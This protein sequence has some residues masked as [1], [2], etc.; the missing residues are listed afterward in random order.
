MKLWSVMLVM[1]IPEWFSTMIPV[2][3]PSPVIVYPLPLMRILSVPTVKHVPFTLTLLFNVTLFVIVPQTVER[4]TT[5]TGFLVIVLV[6]ERAVFPVLSF[7]V[8]LHVVVPLSRIVE[9]KS[10]PPFVCFVDRDTL[11][12][13]SDASLSAS[14]VTFT[15]MI[16][17][18]LVVFSPLSGVMSVM[19]GGVRSMV[20]FGRMLPV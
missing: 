7:A 18:S 20:M 14:S 9:N 10:V 2:P 12:I 3:N 4:V 19:V 6:W 16:V 15:V 1:C 5:S 11:L 8:I 17:E 13:R